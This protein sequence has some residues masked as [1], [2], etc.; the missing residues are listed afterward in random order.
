MSQKLANRVRGKCK[1]VVVSDAYILAPWADALASNDRQ[2]WG[3]HAEAM[4]FAGQKFTSGTVDGVVKMSHRG[5]SNSGL[6]GIRVAM[7]LG[8]TRVLLLGF[9]MGG[10]HFF[11][12]HPEP[13]K[14]TPPARFEVFKAQFARFEHPGV[15][16]INCTPGS[17]LRCFPQMP[18]SEALC[19]RG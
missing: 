14:N 15:E 18:L 11:G 7:K 10:D 4:K 16:I 5:G 12:H 17:A 2:W 13:L 8:A 1:V 19:V 6:L 9:D 3:H